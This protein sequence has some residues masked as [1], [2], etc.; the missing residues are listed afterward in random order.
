MLKVEH[1]FFL[2]LSGLLMGIWG[3]WAFDIFTFIATYLSVNILSAQ[4]VMRSIASMVFMIPAGLSIA[5]HNLV[6]ISI[7]K[8][9]V[10]AIKYYYK[11]CMALSILVVLL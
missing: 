4:T 3:W 6:G 2:G 10:P 7:G 8:G 5:C 1:Q 11:L 9:S